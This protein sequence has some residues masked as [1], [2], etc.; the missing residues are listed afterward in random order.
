MRR[1]LA[2]PILGFCLG[3]L[4]QAQERLTLEVRPPDQRFHFLSELHAPGERPLVLALRGGSAKGL[5]HAGVLRRLEEEG[6]HP[7]GLVG[8]SAGSFAATLYAAGFGGAGAE[9]VFER[10]DFSLVLDDR[11]RTPGLSASEDED[12][13]GTLMGLSF[14]RGRLVLV[15]GEDRAR[16]LRIALFETL[17][18]AQAL[19]GS[20]FDRL[21]TKLR[22]VTSS[23]TR[24]EAR[25][26][27]SGDLV[28]SV[29]ASMSIPGLLAPV[30]IGDERLVDGGL[31]EN[32]PAMAARAA[33]PGARILGV[34]I[35]RTWD[36]TPPT[37]LLSLLNRSLDL[38]MR[39]TESRSEADSDLVIRPETDQ[40]DEFAYRGQESL[41]FEAGAKALDGALPKLETLLM[42]G[43]EAPAAN[44][45]RVEGPP[46]PLLDALV[47]E[48]RPAQG[49]WRRA[50]LWRLLRRAHRRLPLAR[51][52][53]DLP[54]SVQGEATFHWEA[55]ALI[56]HVVLELPGGWDA[57]IKARV[58]QG[59]RERGLEAGHPFH[60]TQ[61]G[62]L[63][64]ELIAEGIGKGA[65]VLDLRG[66]GFAE[67]V[68]TLTVQE[69][70]LV[71]VEVEPGPLA[72]QTHAATRELEDQVLRASELE[73]VLGRTRDR[74]GFQR[75]ETRLEERDE[76]LVLRL[77]PV[78]S[79][80]TLVNI[81]LA[82]ESDWGIHGG[83]LVRGRNLFGTGVGGSIEAAADSLQ[84]HLDGH[85]GWSLNALPALSLGA[86]GSWS[87]HDVRG[88]V[89]F[90]EATAD[91][92]LRFTRKEL[93]L[94]AILRWGRE[95]RGRLGFA[96]LQQ[97]GTF[98]MAETRSNTPKATVA[99]A[100][101]E[102]DNLDFHT[103]PT[104]GSLLRLSVDRS[105]SVEGQSEPYWRSY[106]RFQRQQPLGSAWGLMLDAEVAL[107]DKAPPDL[108]WIGGG[109]DSFIGTRSA[110]YLMPNM[111][112]LKIGL[113]YTQ[114]TILGTGW[115]IGPRYDL[116]R[117]SD[118]PST[119][120]DGLRIEGLGLVARTVLRDFYVE[121]S[122]GWVHLYLGPSSQ[123][124]HR[125]SFLLGARPFDPWRRK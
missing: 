90:L 12:S 70:K 100:W 92:A 56:Q 119:L 1:H 107:A 85:V 66:S 116:G 67:G 58:A 82:Y 51:A 50:D 53:V 72:A 60:P 8:T 29:K 88:G 120:R 13:H 102:W 10:R 97:Q 93:G 27:A 22:V 99:R 118:Q 98:T 65:A 86:F 108:W 96:A 83:V 62:R 63:E 103:L 43:S 104:E 59:L 14:A 106:T 26:L 33:F 69:P 11:R 42:A 9:R 64:Q 41:L 73:E 89:L 37:D 125:V 16:R 19:G 87:Q 39:V 21:G 91:L 15:P 30:A 55:T 121:L 32:L 45:L 57:A 52:W 36:A 20:D 78:G 77:R 79:Q 61:F 44:G 28:D 84:K 35:G 5:A 4:A 34:N 71:R 110:A 48:T 68:L 94:E 111:A 24:G 81:T 23:L 101:L 76:G 6:W 18:R 54:A 38:S 47:A 124:E 122:A 117:G 112:A 105:L 95:D 40:V 109:S 46:H 113:P 7:S 74:L 25:V 2:L 31:V 80:P 49:P 17:A 3:A 123:R 114:A 115:Q 75:L